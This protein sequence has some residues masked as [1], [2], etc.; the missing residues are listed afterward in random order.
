MLCSLVFQVSLGSLEIIQFTQHTG[1]Y[2]RP[3]SLVLDRRPSFDHIL[4]HC[5]LYWQKGTL[6]IN[7]F[8]IFQISLSCGILLL[9]NVHHTGATLSGPPS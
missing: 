4:C 7:A 1:A 5:K 8:R 6:T 2:A 3:Y 9:E